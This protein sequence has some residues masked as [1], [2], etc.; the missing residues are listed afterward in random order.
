MR[1]MPISIEYDLE[2][3]ILT[4]QRLQIVEDLPDVCGVDITNICHQVGNISLIVSDLLVNVVVSKD[5]I[6]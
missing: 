1:A 3:L 4:G 6:D 5:F 2:L